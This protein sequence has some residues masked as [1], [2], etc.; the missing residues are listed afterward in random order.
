[1]RIGGGVVLLLAIIFTISSANAISEG[2]IKQAQ[3][4]SHS[5]CT[6]GTGTG[7]RRVW[8]VV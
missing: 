8:H 6:A 4:G 1:M 7:K 2:E 5:G 3:A